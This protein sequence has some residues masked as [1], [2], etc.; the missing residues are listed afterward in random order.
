MTIL[1]Y[2]QNLLT[3]FSTYFLNIISLVS[4]HGMLLY[5][6]LNQ[7]MTC[8]RTEWWKKIRIIQVLVVKSYFVDLDIRSSG[9]WQKRIYIASVLNVPFGY[10]FFSDWWKYVLK[11]CHW[12]AFVLAYL[13][14]NNVVTKS[15]KSAGK[16]TE[17]VNTAIKRFHLFNAQL[18]FIENIY[19]DYFS[20][21]LEMNCF[22]L[23]D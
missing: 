3:K 10:N 18:I 2:L 1:S 6:H 23:W 15:L 14:L 5:Q 16:I 7:F 9:V 20:Q 21:Q 4:V 19:L 12:L 17:M 13:Y 11:Y 8:P 22:C